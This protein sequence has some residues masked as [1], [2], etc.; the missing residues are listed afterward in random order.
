AFVGTILAVDAERRLHAVFLK[1]QDS[2]IPPIGRYLAGLFGL[3]PREVAVLMPLL[4]GMSPAEVADELGVSVATVRSHLQR[5][6]AKTR[7]E[8]QVDLVRVVLQSIPPVQL[9]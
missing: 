8:R 3:T 1:A 7:T 4:K 9:A 5:L 2:E 6:F